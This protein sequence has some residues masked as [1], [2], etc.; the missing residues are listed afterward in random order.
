L[1]ICVGTSTAVVN[2]QDGSQTLRSIY[3]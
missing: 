3:Q 1:S 2:Q